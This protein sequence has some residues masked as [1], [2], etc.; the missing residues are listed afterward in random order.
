MKGEL[1]YFHIG[2]A[3]GGSQD[4]F[5][6]LWMHF[7]GC[8]AATACDLSIYLALYKGK[9]RLYPYDVR[10]LERQEYVN[11]SKMMK[12]Y[13]HPRIFGIDRLAI[14][15]EGFSD[16]LKACGEN[17]LCVLTWDGNKSLLSTKEII[18]QQ[19]AKGFP[20][21]CLL[22]KHKDSA[23]KAY[24]WHWFLLTGYDEDKESFLVKAV[25]Y[26]AYQWLDLA[27]LWNTGYK[28]KGGLILLQE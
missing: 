1:Q 3:Y 4:W 24:V 5:S 15:Q 12:P 6:G 20:L 26:G 28:K 13:L 27:G 14:Y 23:F 19:L 16:Y 7:G 10:H 17:K 22:L 18:K 9:I 8:A 25:T 11:F 2:T 21:P